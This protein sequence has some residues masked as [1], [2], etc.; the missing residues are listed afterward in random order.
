MGEGCAADK[1]EMALIQCCLAILLTFAVPVHAQPGFISINCGMAEDSTYIDIIDTTYHSDAKYIETG[2]NY[3]LSKASLPTTTLQQ[4]YNNVRSFPNGSRNCYNLSEITKGTKYLLRFYMWY[5][6]YDGINSI[7]QFDI[8]IGVN[9]WM[10]IND[11]SSVPFVRELILMAKKN[12]MSV[13]LVNTG[14][15]TP[16]ISA[17]ELRPLNHSMY[18]IVNE[19]HSLSRWDQYDL[20]RS[21]YNN[22]DV[23]AGIRYPDDPYD[24]LWRP[25]DVIKWSSFN[26]SF[27]V[28]NPNVAFQPPS[29]VMMT[30]VRPVNESDALYHNWTTDELG[31]QLQVY[32]H[33]AELEQLNATQKRE[34]T[35]CYGDNLCNNSTI[36]PE[37]LVTTTVEPPR[38]LTGQAQYSCTL[39][40]TSNSTHPPILNAIEIFAIRQYND[41]PTRDEDVEAILDIKSTYQL[42]RNWMGDPCVPKTFSWQGLVCNYT[43]SDFPTILSLNLSSFGLK[44]EI[45]ASLANL[46]SIQSLDLSWN[47]LTGPIPDFLGDLPSLSLLNLSGN[48]LSGSVP[49]NL[50]T[51]VNRGSLQLSIDNNPNLVTP[52]NDIKKSRK[53]IVTVLASVISTLVLL[54]IV[55]ILLLKFAQRRRQ[56]APIVKTNNQYADID[57]LPYENREFT[58]AEVLSITNNF[59]RC[60]GK[61]GFGTVYHGQMTNGTQVAV[62]MLSP[63]SLSL[64]SIKSTCQGPTEFENEAHLLMRVHHRNLVLFIGYCQE[65]GNLALIYE[66]MAQGHL[67]SHLEDSKSD[68]L[69]WDRRLRIALDVAQGLEYLH[70]GCKPPIIHRDVKTA[71]ILLNERLEAKIGDFGLSKVFSDDF[72][73]VSTAVK[74]TFGYLDPEYYNSNNLTEKSDVYSFGVVLLQLITGKTAVVQISGSAPRGLI[75]WAIPVFVGGDIMDV[76]DPKLEGNY[77]IKSIQKVA[78]IAHA[79]TLPKSIDRPHMRDV[80]VEL[81][82]YIGNEKA[83]ESESAPES[84]GCMYSGPGQTTSEIFSYLSAR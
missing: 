23:T 29:K 1:S 16:F 21:K 26:T 62:K 20:G 5:G 82:E 81:K 63:E 43:L 27:G 76:I 17:L 51:K 47:N 48:Q 68:A 77:D 45:A 80:V 8:Y 54:T 42:K 18:K 25:F 14:L 19:T 39:K 33:F 41:T 53:V 13:C 34:F 46:I 32:L 7:P 24:L 73:H 69:S 35:V 2:V 71:N 75:D 38:I 65:D 52:V 4:L 59:Q 6:N 36:R 50:V 57:S 44:G 22:V 12:Y 78:E 10:I 49:S 37:Y 70:D 28:T 61:G 60:I 31:L 66:Y 58:Y 15:G 64:E 74:G 83:L 30:A 9:R 84:D 79:C 72:T 3:N 11:R 55:G 40:R 67:G 56:R